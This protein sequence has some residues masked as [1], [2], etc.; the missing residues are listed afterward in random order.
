MKVGE[1]EINNPL[2]QNIYKLIEII[3]QKMTD[4]GL[5]ITVLTIGLFII[6]ETIWV[7][8]NLAIIKYSNGLALFLAVMHAEDNSFNMEMVCLYFILILYV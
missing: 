3:N 8:K 1:A 6:Y 2:Y 5:L 4:R 7:D